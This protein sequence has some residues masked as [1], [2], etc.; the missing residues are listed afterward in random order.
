MPG[1]FVET[2]GDLRENGMGLFGHCTAPNVGHGS[3]LDLDALIARLGED[4]VYIN[5]RR[6]A[7]A[8]VCRRC[9]HRGALITVTA[10]TMTAA[11]RASP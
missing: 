1:G 5:D 8:L 11:T 2:L 4:H 3:R 6:L 7:S 9:G 10:N